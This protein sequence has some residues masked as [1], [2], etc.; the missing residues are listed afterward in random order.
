MHS[1]TLQRQTCSAG[2]A[3]P[4]VCSECEGLRHGLDVAERN[5]ERVSKERTD[6]GTPLR[7]REQCCCIASAGCGS[8]GAAGASQR[9]SGA[10][11]CSSGRFGR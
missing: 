11:G 4:T 8:P 2:A 7:T 10:H 6:L 5:L 9:I 3:E 1:R